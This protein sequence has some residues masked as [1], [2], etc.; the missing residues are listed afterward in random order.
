MISGVDIPAPTQILAHD[1][2][3]PA[4]FRDACLGWSRRAGGGPSRSKCALA[5]RH[6]R[7]RSETDPPPLLRQENGEADTCRT[8]FQ[9]VMQIC[10]DAKFISNRLGESSDDT[11][12]GFGPP[13]ARSG[14]NSLSTHE[15]RFPCSGHPMCPMVT[16]HALTEGDRHIFPGFA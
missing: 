4:T 2:S 1:D 8:T 12:Q 7:V 15:L 6:A 13:I 11:C 16:V 3:K 9:V 14:S 10:R 5:R